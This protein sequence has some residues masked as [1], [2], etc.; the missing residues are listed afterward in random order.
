MQTAALRP[1]NLAAHKSSHVCTHTCQS[2]LCHL[3]GMHLGCHL[4]AVLS[5]PRVHHLHICTYAWHGCAA[6]P[7]HAL[8]CICT[9]MQAMAT[10]ITCNAC[11]HAH[12]MAAR[13]RCCVATLIAAFPLLLDMMCGCFSPATSYRQNIV[14]ITGRAVMTM[15]HTETS[16]AQ[17]A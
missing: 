16:Q 14:L 4:P 3:D 9:M 6:G 10:I 8:H 1:D 12:S 2:N 15:R 5:R 11:W 7:M 13:S 17:P